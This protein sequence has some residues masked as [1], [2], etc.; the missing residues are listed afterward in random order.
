MPVK[1][2][3]ENFKTWISLHNVKVTGESL[4][5]DYMAEGKYTHKFK[6]IIEE[7]D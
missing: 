5:A 1:R 2:W 7:K 4:P 6:N 3:L